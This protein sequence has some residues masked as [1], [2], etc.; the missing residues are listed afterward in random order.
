MN[1]STYD[2]LPGLNHSG[3]K[4]L[5]KSPAHYQ[6]WKSGL[7]GESS[8]A[9]SL[10]IAIH[11]AVL[12][13]ERFKTDYVSLPDT[14]HLPTASKKAAFLTKSAKKEFEGTDI[15]PL[16]FADYQLVLRIFESVMAHPYARYLIEESEAEQVLTWTDADSGAQC[17][18]RADLLMHDRGVLSDLKSVQDAS[19]AG[20]ARGIAQYFWHR[21]AAFYADGCG[22]HRFNF[23]AVE[24]T[25][26]YGVMV[27]TIPEHVLDAG[28]QLYKP[29]AAL[30]QDCVQSGEWPAYSQDVTTVNLPSWAFSNEQ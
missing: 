30:Y 14:S 13:P 29:L 19:S 22:A 23:I 16:S 11:C 6:V 12:E 9:M 24:K 15:V 2:L 8:P 26:P 21:Q 20:F 5:E 1:Q 4:W 18:C 25:P 10:G 7:L 17:K 3:M 28:R 27:F